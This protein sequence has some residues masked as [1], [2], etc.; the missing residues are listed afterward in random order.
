M[1][2]I[3]LKKVNKAWDYLNKKLNREERKEVYERLKIEFKW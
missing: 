2:F 3:D 1:S